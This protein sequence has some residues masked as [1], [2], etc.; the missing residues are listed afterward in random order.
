MA[1]VETLA[2]SI[3]QKILISLSMWPT[4]PL[5]VVALFQI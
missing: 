3:L 5:R 2:G 4:L 1:V